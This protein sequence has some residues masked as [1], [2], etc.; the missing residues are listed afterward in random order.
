MAKTTTTFTTT[1]TCHLLFT[2]VHPR[3]ILL[4]RGGEAPLINTSSFSSLHSMP[5]H[6]GAL[7]GGGSSASLIG[8]V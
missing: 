8:Q 4:I 1:T 3:F 7:R 6:G 2:G 5:T